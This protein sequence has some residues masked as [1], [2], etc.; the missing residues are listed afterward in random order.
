MTKISVIVPVYK[1]EKYVGECINSILAQTFKDFELI[2]VDDGSPDKSGEICDSYA[3][4]DNRIKV[5]HKKNGGVSS[6][7]N[8]GID[9]AV[10]EWLCFI[11]SD[12]TIDSTYL[13][14]FK[15]YK[16]GYDMYLQ[17]Y[18]R[19]TPDS[20]IEKYSFEDFHSKDYYEILAFSEDIR[21]I[22]SPCYKLYR[23]DIVI[24]KGLSYDSNTSYGED[25]LFTLDYVR[26]INK[27]HYSIT[28]GYNYIISDGESLS[29][30]RIPLKEIIYYT[31][32]SRKKQMD[33]FHASNSIVYLN[34][35]N[36]RMEQNITKTV[37]ELFASTKSKEEYFLIHSSYRCLIES[38]NLCGISILRRMYL[39][40]WSIMKPN[41][42]YWI[43]IKIL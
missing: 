38:T 7:R 43:L 6:A 15:L 36:R 26:N 1:V 27:I 23:R 22:N 32:V 31:V 35:I 42:S 12:D 10:G 2:L 20:K 41:L 16:K 40:L 11:D 19:I 8:F 25:H 5:F 33:I 9:K 17:G 28:C 24:D 14:D 21:I 34:A 18:K 4:K 29:H 3:K 37:R 13:E 39:R 30:K